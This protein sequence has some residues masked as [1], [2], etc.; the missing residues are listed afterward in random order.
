MNATRCPRRWIFAFGVQLAGISLGCSGDESPT[1]SKSALDTSA[2]HE[3][4][5]FEIQRW[6][7]STQIWEYT[8]DQV[9]VTLDWRFVAST[10][11]VAGVLVSGGYTIVWDNPKSEKVNVHVDKFLFQDR[12]QIPVTEL[13]VNDSFD[14]NPNSTRQRTG[15]FEINLANLAVSG[16]VT[17][18]TMFA[19]VG[20]EP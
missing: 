19:G 10:E 5:Y 14:I 8:R 15:T 7:A 11:T 20:Y 13:V 9:T 18:F 1:A 17:R 4:T 2:R 16:E 6:N 12:T 3:V